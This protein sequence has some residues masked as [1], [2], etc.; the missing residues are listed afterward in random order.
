M[1]TKRTRSFLSFDEFE[2]THVSKRE[3]RFPTDTYDS[4]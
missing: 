3:R 2:D 1:K 4:P